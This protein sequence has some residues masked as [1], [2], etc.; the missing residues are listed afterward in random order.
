MIGGTGVVHSEECRR[1]VETE[2]KKDPD[3]AA[4]INVANTKRAE[5]VKKNG[6]KRIAVEE[7][8]PRGGQ[9]HRAERT[10]LRIR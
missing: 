10:Q 1:R 2:M 9:P 6:L 3:E 5:F 8:E 7:M 4:R